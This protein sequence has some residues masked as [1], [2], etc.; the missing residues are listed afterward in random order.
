MSYIKQTRIEIIN[1]YVFLRENNQK[2]SSET[3]Q[4]MLDASLEKLNKLEL[5]EEI[6]EKEQT[7]I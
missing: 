2:I 3:L 1:A 7:K 6:Y 5:S 4:F